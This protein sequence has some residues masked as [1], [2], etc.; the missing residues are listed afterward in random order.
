M[1][2]KQRHWVIAMFLTEIAT[3][4]YW[5]N[6]RRWGEAGSNPNRVHTLINRLGNWEHAFH[7]IQ[8]LQIE[9]PVQVGKRIALCCTKENDQD[10][11]VQKN[12]PD[13]TSRFAVYN[14]LLRFYRA[15]NPAKLEDAEFLERIMH[16]YKGA[17]SLLLGW[18]NREI[19]PC[20]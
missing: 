3:I 15:Y 10:V 18:N 6:G 12:A 1:S 14:R 17:R 13:Q 11:I 19:S 16:F 2:L 4:L 8:N 5:D 9:P 7:K 20:T